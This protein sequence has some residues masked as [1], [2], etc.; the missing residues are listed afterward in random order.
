MYAHAS[1]DTAGEPGV[2]RLMPLQS[3][4]IFVAVF[5]FILFLLICFSFL[6]SA[7]VVFA[8]LFI[9]LYGC[10]VHCFCLV[11]LANISFL[12]LLFNLCSHF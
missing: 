12:A 5:G 1:Q 9:W 2:G 11:P 7:V 3:L 10:G 4:N 6:L 8:L